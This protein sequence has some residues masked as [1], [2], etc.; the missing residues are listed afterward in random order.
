MTGHDHP[1][2]DSHATPAAARQ[3]PGGCAYHTDQPAPDQWVAVGEGT[4]MD[5]AGRQAHRLVVGTGP[6]EAA[7]VGALERRCLD[8]TAGYRW[9]DRGEADRPA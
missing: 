3:T 9:I 6:T 5:E 8:G 1:P 4:D 7:A 2:M